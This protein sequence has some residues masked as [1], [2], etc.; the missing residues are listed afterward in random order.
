[1]CL[2]WQIRTNPVR[3]FDELLRGHSN[4]LP[5]L[6]I[7]A[8]VMRSSARAS[9][10]IEGRKLRRTDSP[11]TA[12][13]PGHD[14]EMEVRR[15]LPAVDAVVLERE[16]SERAIRADERLRDS[17]GR[18]QHL[19]AFVIG[20]IQQRRDVPTR[21]HAALPDFELPRVH[22]RQRMSALGDDG[23][24]LFATGDPL[25]EIAWGSW[26]KFEHL[27]LRKV[28]ASQGGRRHAATAS[29]PAYRPWRHERTHGM[30]TTGSARRH[31]CLF[32][33]R[34]WEARRKV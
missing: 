17:P 8:R 29:R 11:V 13:L 19:A 16:Y 27:P 6:R 18:G 1:M 32:P 22:H 2:A 7:A 25:A 23:P 9:G 20:Q 5:T 21:D 10:A 30:T 3:R 26:R 31:V 4:P 24:S 28:M 14:M 33:T 12:L 34:A 15:F